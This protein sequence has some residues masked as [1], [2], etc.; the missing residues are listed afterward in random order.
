[1]TT[2]RGWSRVDGLTLNEIVT[3]TQS[4][5]YKPRQEAFLTTPSKVEALFG[6]H[7]EFSEANI[8]INRGYFY[9]VITTVI[10]SVYI[11]KR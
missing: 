3:A 5:L 10:R 8:K 11:P 6:N 2:A 1:M 7:A 9:P 4:R